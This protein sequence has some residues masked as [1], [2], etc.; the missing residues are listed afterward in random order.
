MVRIL[1]QARDHRYERGLPHLADHGTHHLPRHQRQRQLA[2]RQH[3]G[4]AG[5]ITA[6]LAR[7]LQ[8]SH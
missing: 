8:H 1:G 3:L 5:R 6:H 7:Y 2:V 4:P